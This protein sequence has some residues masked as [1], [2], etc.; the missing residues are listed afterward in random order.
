M[1]FLD[2]CAYIKLL[3]NTR[4]SVISKVESFLT[5][6]RIFIVNVANHQTETLFK[7]I[8]QGGLTYR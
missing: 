2:A 6:M 8:S 7:V 4:F 1:S 5:V 3:A